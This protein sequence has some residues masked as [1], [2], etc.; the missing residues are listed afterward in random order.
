M[1]SN[2]LKS[3][4]VDNVK[5]PGNYGDGGGLYL[6]VSLGKTGISKSWCF[7]WMSGGKQRE[8]GLG[9]LATWS[10]KEARDRAR[11]CRQIVADGGDPI[12]AKRAKIA[13]TRVLALKTKT[14]KECALE[15]LGDKVAGFKNDKHRQQWRSTLETYAFPKLG[16]LPLQQIDSELVLQVLRPVFKKTP[17]TGSRLRQRIERVIEYAKP[18]G[19]FKGDN[20]ASR[21]VLKDHLPTREK[22]H[23]P[24]LHYEQ[25]PAFMTDLRSRDSLSAKVLEFCIL[26]A[27]RTQEVLG[28]MWSEIDF[29]KRL[30]TVPASRMKKKR[31]HRV[32]LSDSA[33]TLLRELPTSNRRKGYV[34]PNGGGL[35]LSQQAMSELLKG[36]AYPS[37][38]EGKMVTVHGM[39]STFSDWS[40]DKTDY[41]PAV[42]ELALAHT[43]SN[44]T[45]AAYRRG[46]ALDKRV[47]LMD[48]WATY[49]G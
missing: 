5:K 31:E 48:A 36:M 23:H 7:R 39:R 34:F 2:Q 15:F 47:G 11:H 46:D 6:Q 32:P 35:P 4:F 16:P 18:L 41:H 22:G 30:W 12:E 40:H 29:D 37:T 49:C 28:A 42:I 20:P 21:E 45:A 19:L 9:S 44:K 27:T 14:F 25:M 17:E 38:T 8:F 33:V 10:L 26:T 3:K 24:A 1:K 13:E 43:V